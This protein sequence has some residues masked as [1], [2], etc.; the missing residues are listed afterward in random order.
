L[1]QSENQQAEAAIEAGD[2]P[3]AARILVAVVEKDP[4]NWRAYNDI[5]IISW[6]QKSWEDSFAMFKRAAELK[7]DYTDALINLFDACLKLK[8]IDQ[9]LPLF[10]KALELNPS[11]EEMATLVESIESQGEDIY[12]CERALSLGVY[13]PRVEEA[14]KLLQDGKLNEAMAQ[15]IAINDSEGPSAEVFSGLGV[16]AFYKKEYTDAFSLFL[17]S[18]KLNPLNTDTYLNLLDAAKMTGHI[19]DACKV[20]QIYRKQFAALDAIKQEFDNLHL[21]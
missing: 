13:N 17:E 10:K 2:L 4:T 1:Y 7:P 19:E 9:G 21:S 12:L 18:I 14:A 5:G 8:R 15:F 6:L 20:Y 16:I 3:G 11:D